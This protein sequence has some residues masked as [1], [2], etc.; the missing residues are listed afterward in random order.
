MG[1]SFRGVLILLA[2]VVIATSAATAAPREAELALYDATP[3]VRLYKEDDRVVR[4]YGKPFSSGETPSESASLFLQEHA[5]LFDAEATDLADATLQPVVYQPETEDYKFTLVKFGQYRDD[6]PV[7]R[8]DARVLIRNGWDNEA[9]WAGSSLRDLGDFQIETTM[10]QDLERHEFVNERFDLSKVRALEHTPGLLIWTRPEIVIWAGLEG[11]RANPRIAL[12]FTGN[13]HA[14]GSR[15]DLNYLFL[16]DVETGEI[17]YSEN[18]MIDVDVVGNVS[19][20][21]TEGE[22]ADYCHDEVVQPLKHLEVFSGTSSGFSDHDGN[23]IV[24]DGGATVGAGLDGMWFNVIN[25][26]G[27]EV[28]ESEPSTFDLLFNQSNDIEAVRAQVNAYVE[29]N[30][31]RDFTVTYN[32]SYPTFTD[33]NIRTTVMRTDG[34]CPGNAWY[35]TPD[36]SSPTGYSINFCAE[37]SSNPNTAFSSVVHHEFGHHLVQAAGSGQGQYGEGMGDVMSVLINDHNMIG[38]GFNST[39]GCMTS[40]RNAINSLSYP[41]S[42]VHSCAG[43][44]SGSIWDS[45]TKMI[46]SNPDNYID[47]LANMAVNA[48]LLHA[49]SSITPSVTIDY[50]TLD[51]DDGSILN[52]TPHYDEIAAGFALHN[53]DAPPVQR[54]MGIS[55]PDGLVAGGGEGGPFTPS[56]TVYTVENLD[57]DKIL[58]NVVVD[59]PWLAVEGDHG[60]LDPGATAEVT[61]SLTA[62][63]ATLG[64]GIHDAN[65]EFLN[66]TNHFGDLSMEALLEVDRFEFGAV[67]TPL[68][69]PTFQT[70]TSTINVREPGCVGDINVF[71][72]I[73]HGAIGGLRVELVSPRNEVLLL[74]APAGGG[75]N[76]YTT[77]DDQGPTP[78][79]GPGSLADFNYLDASGDWTLRVVNNSYTYSGT[80]NDWSLDIQL[81]GIGCPPLVDDLEVQVPSM[82]SSDITLTATSPTG[83][84]LDYIIT[85]LPAYGILEDPAR[86]E[87]TTVPYT[88]F[89]RGNVV[90]YT[91]LNGF[92]G[93]DRFEYRADDGRES[94]DARVNVEVGLRQTG[95]SFDLGSDP[96]WSA[97]GEW[98]WGQPSGGGSRS[99]DPE[100]GYTGD[101]V[102]GYNL[103]GDYANHLGEETLTSG[104]IDCSDLVGVEVAF[105]RWLGIESNAFDSAAFQ[106][107][108]DGTLWTE[109]WSNPYSNIEEDGWSLASYDISEIADRQPAVYLRWVM[110]VTDGTVTYSG[111]NIDDI[112][113]TGVDAPPIIELAVEPG[114]LSWTAMAGASGYDLIRGDLAALRASG[115]QFDQLALTCLQNDAGG[116]D[117]PHSENPPAGAGY[118]YL[119]RGDGG[120]EVRSYDSFAISQSGV[121]DAGIESSGGNCP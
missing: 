8:A 72:D 62:E 21:A 116:S 42:G 22:G 14:T 80:L 49:G 107:S 26:A 113:L 90:T 87:I 81:L 99:V 33:T 64:S 57:E 24:E 28:T 89:Q 68:T 45:R 54:G 58:Y 35:S 109:V 19:G 9:V 13:N 46:A 5:E 118:W 85:S 15:G 50:L 3:G 12:R 20:Y 48:M 74:H 104:A 92:T 29:A 43:V 112:E 70:T 18:L 121:R 106:V 88:L 117:L 51:D 1:Q 103:D 6:I 76:I 36:W 53:L 77:Y 111:W 23:F 78:P 55:P 82:A 120:A 4:V 84:T 34:Y 100:S 17:L 10:K 105:R 101:E 63:A 110:G 32:P 2:L 114:Q 7:F 98:A 94:I 65:I 71:V 93:V 30:R 83:G 61:V 69:M 108:T 102:Y 11:V 25:V 67:D 60:L 119:V 38:R 96:G 59:E 86:N 40:L 16:A 31:V 97:T 39:M 52:G 44:L 27:A 95:A 56:S 73:T 115:G 91:P 47:I 66:L 75:S 79:A 37:G 41:C